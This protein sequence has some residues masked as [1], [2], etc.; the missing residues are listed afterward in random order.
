MAWTF[1]GLSFRLR[2]AGPYQELDRAGSYHEC[3]FLNFPRSL[4]NFVPSA[5]VAMICRRASLELWGSLVTCQLH[6][7]Q[8]M[9]RL[10][11]GTFFA[12]ATSA[13]MLFDWR[14]GRTWR[15]AKKLWEKITQSGMDVSWLFVRTLPPTTMCHMCHHSLPLG[16]MQRSIE[17]RWLCFH[18]PSS[19]QQHQSPLVND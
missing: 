1:L 19:V 3:V 16:I 18:A 15:L 2:T 12:T 8:V 6:G 14:S 9:L 11:P 4:V 13:R 10:I 17:H 7:W 5:Y